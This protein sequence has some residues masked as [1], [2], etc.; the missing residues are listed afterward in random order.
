MIA[1]NF[2]NSRTVINGAWS[3]GYDVAPIWVP[4]GNVTPLRTTTIPSLIQ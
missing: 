4:G 2:L 3:Q 1:E